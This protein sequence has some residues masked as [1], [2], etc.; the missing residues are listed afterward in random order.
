MKLQRKYFAKPE[1]E[2]EEKA[3]PI[4]NKENDPDYLADRGIVAGTM[5]SLLG[6]GALGAKK[7]LL[8]QGIIDRK[9][10]I[11]KAG[12]VSKY[13]LIPAGLIVA[14]ASGYKKYK[15]KK[16]KKNEDKA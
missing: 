5:T 10:K 7:Y 2:K 1:E 9:G 12:N 15:N 6:A 4:I 14:G 11:A 16:S 8:K 13:V 3:K